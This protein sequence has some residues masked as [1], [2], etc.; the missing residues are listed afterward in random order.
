[1]RQLQD[2]G[3]VQLDDKGISVTHSGRYLLRSIAMPFDAYLPRGD[4]V[5][6]EPRFSRAI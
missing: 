6:A 4:S 1:M 2:D 5:T 3:L